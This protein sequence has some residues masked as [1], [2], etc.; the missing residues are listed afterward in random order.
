MRIIFTAVALAVSGV[1]ISAPS[2]AQ[3]SSANVEAARVSL[4]RVPWQC[5][6]APEIACGGVAKPILLE[7]EQDPSISEA[8]VNRAGTVLAVIGSEKS[9]H[10]SR[11]NA[12]QSLL[13]E[14]FEKQ[15]ATEI[16]G[17][18][19][20]VELIRFNSKD[21]WYRGVQVD[22]LSREEADII[23][24][25]LARR[26]QANVPLTDDKA[27]ALAAAVASVFKS[28]FLGDPSAPGISNKAPA[29]VS[30]PERDEQL[31]K[32]ARD[33]LDAAGVAVFAEA[34]RKGHRPLPGEQ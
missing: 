27:N 15:I 21:G 32:V 24:A 29:K 30:R 2:Y 28:Q 8:W 10:E 17:E 4:F 16:G 23:G 25:R 5:P 22:H 34:V 11:T 33:H 9:G 18:A 26:V 31:I 13:L 12:V 14:I 3:G 19:R 20:T 6:A 1:V 7:L